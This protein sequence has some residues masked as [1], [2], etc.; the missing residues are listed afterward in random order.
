[1]KPRSLEEI[2]KEFETENDFE[3]WQKEI[4]YYYVENKKII[5]ND[6]QPLLKEN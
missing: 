3:N 6:I 2:K 4:I 5:R 1:M